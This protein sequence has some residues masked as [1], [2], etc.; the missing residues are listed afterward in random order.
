MLLL[1]LQELVETW[2][3]N[4]LADVVGQLVILLFLEFC[5][6]K[7]STFLIFNFILEYMLNDWCVVKEAVDIGSYAVVSLQNGLVSIADA[8]MYL[9]ALTHLTFELES[10]LL[11]GLLMSHGGMDR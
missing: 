1:R 9:V 6:G 11:S 3:I 4:V 5:R 2:N 8:L 7:F 10:D